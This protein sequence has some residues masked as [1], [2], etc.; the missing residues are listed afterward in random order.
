MAMLEV[1]SLLHEHDSKSLALM[2]IESHVCEL[3]STLDF[4]EHGHDVRILAEAPSWCTN[5]DQRDVLFQ[6]QCAPFTAH[7]QHG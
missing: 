4:L 5:H 3:Q 1:L 2:S 7:L 6:L